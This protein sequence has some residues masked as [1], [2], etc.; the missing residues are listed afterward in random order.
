MAARGLP[1]QVACRVLGV[2]EAGFHAHR[3]RPPSARSIRHALL[4]DVIRQ[5]HADARGT[6]GSRRVRAELVMGRGLMVGRC[7]VELLM[8]RACRD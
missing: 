7:A 3:R 6:Y 2:S 5:V 1:I 8:R 4:T